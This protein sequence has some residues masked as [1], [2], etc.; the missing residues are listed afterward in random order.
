MTEASV[1]FSPADLVARAPR[2]IRQRYDVRDTMLYALGIGAG[3][4]A[5]DSAPLKYVYEKELE[6]FPTMA[7]VLANPGFW[8]IDP[9]YGIDWQKVLH[10]EQSIVFHRV[11]PAAGEVV[12]YFRIRAV[13]DKGLDK[14]SVL[15]A[16]RK[17]HDAASGELLATVVQGSFLRGNGG[18]GTL[19]DEPAPQPHALPV[20]RAPDVSISLPTRTEQALLYRLSGDYNPLHADPAVA[21]A[22]GLPRPVLHGLCTYALAG[23]AALAALC[24]DEPARL[25]RLDV[26]FSSPVF[27]GDT[28]CIELWR[29]GEGRAAFRALA[30]ERGV[31][32]LNNGYVEYC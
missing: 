19:A 8:Q 5:G 18:C 27:P 26:R 21:S 3:I 11:L 31:V 30:H 29:E 9:Q 4:D 16:E 22:A 7:A 10:G 6:T 28:L 2:E 20:G 15:Y 1:R 14:G 17:I 25:H 24:G 32:V 23:R 13:Y 12:G